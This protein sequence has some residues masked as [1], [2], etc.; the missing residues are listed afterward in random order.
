MR[1]FLNLAMFYLGWLAC[2]AGAA[3]GRLWLGPLVAGGLLLAH[4]A[5]TLERVRET[6]LILLAGLF[7]FAV[8]TWQAWAGLFAF[9]NTSAAPWLSP[10]WMIA[11]WMLFASTLN[12]SMSWLA[13]R[14]GAGAVLGAI[15][16]PA[17]Y[18]AGARLG[19]I[20]LADPRVWSLLGIAAVW[21]VAMPALLVMRDLVSGVPPGTRAPAS[22]SHRGG[23]EVVGA[24]TSKDRRL[25][26]GAPSLKGSPSTRP[27]RLAFFLAAFLVGAPM[28]RPG[29]AKELEGVE[30]P[31][32][33]RQGDVTMRLNCLAL[34]RYKVIFKAYVAALYV[35]EGFGP[36]EV[37]ADVPKRLELQYFWGISAPK[38]AKAGDEILARNID[39]ETLVKLRPRLA[40]LN[41]LYRNVKP[42]D[43]YSLTYVP[44]IGTELAL[45]DEQ[46]GIVEGADFGA[47]YFRIW[48]GDHP[49]DVGLRDQ[50]LS[51]SSPDASERTP[52]NAVH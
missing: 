28:M 52:G 6:R 51:C 41:A 24:A 30:F 31:D 50:L 17:S 45:N 23:C 44:G 33:Y 29:A 21:A 2:V 11:L 42:G 12:A 37:L 9:A 5:W 32:L 7:G 25:I 8:D 1:R 20:D 36:G 10:P 18:W 3:Q 16:G 46:L 14:Y 22:C 4:L 34:L 38:F 39:A 15:F 48:L 49:L 40:R 43:R 19:A 27:T 13:G 26:A 47:A 35:G